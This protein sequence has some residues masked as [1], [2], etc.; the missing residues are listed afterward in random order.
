MTR[1]TPAVLGRQVGFMARTAR[2][3]AR[4]PQVGRHW[5]RTLPTLVRRTTQLRVPWLPYALIDELER[6]ITPG[7]RVFEYGGGGSTTW[8]ADRGARVITVENHPGW[9]A[10]V[11]ALVTGADVDL[12]FVDTGAGYD[13]YV[14]AIDAEPDGSLDVVVVDGRE[15]VRCFAR[16]VPKVAPGGLLII[17]DIDRRR[18]QPVMDLVD[19]PRERVV[20][21]APCKPSLAYT[22]VFRRPA[23]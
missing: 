3:V 1:L 23:G 14:G 20:G 2:D 4:Q 6:T 17:D 5:R 12:R 21:F 22:A 16:A 9:I 15:R 13:A 8:F 10:E 19:W 18:Y 7:M 11:A